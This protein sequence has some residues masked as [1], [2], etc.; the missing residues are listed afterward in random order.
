MDRSADTN[1]AARSF[2]T[3]LLS[4]SG[5]HR[6]DRRP[7]IGLLVQLLERRMVLGRHPVED[8]LLHRRPGQDT[9]VPCRDA[10]MGVP[11]RREAQELEAQYVRWARD[12][13]QREVRS[14]E[15]AAA[16]RV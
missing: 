10:G 9:F 8:L 12:V 15:P 4:S 3:M 16:A 2:L 1:V 6:R 14:R 7:G 13:G 5:N 11:E